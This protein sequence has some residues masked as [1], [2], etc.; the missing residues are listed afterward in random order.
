MPRTGPGK[1]AANQHNNRHENGLV[2][3]GKRIVKQKSNG[4]LNGSPKGGSQSSTPPL[5]TPSTDQPLTL[6]EDHNLNGSLKET[7]HDLDAVVDGLRSREAASTYENAEFCQNGTVSQPSSEAQ[8]PR[9]ADLNGSTREMTYTINPVRLVSSIVKACPIQDTIALLIFLLQLPPALLTTTQY[10]FATLSFVPPSVGPITHLVDLSKGSP[11]SPSLATVLVVSVITILCMMPLWTP[12]QNFALDIAQVQI[13]ITLG[14]GYS[15][16]S[17]YFDSAFVCILVVSA[18]HLSQS[19]DVRQFLAANVLSSW[20]FDVVRPR[21]PHV[22]QTI[23]PFSL[24]TTQHFQHI[25]PGWVRLIPAGHI[26]SQAAMR[27]V[28]RWLFNKNMTQLSKSGKAGDTEASAG[29]ASQDPASE[30]GSVANAAHLTDGQVASPNKIQEKTERISNTK[31]RKR[32]QTL[33]RSQ[34]PFWAALASTKVTVMRE[35]EHSRSGAPGI[36]TPKPLDTSSPDIMQVMGEE[37]RVW[38]LSV[39]PTTIK[40]DVSCATFEEQEHHSTALRPT[41]PF[42]LRVNGANWTSASI[43]PKH[44]TSTTDDDTAQHWIAEVFG[45]PPNGVYQCSMVRFDNEMEF[46][47]LNMKTPAAPDAEQCKSSA[48][49]ITRQTLI[50]RSFISSPATPRLATS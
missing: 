3:P 18:M 31:K 24:V 16:K 37:A 21:L 26:L 22:I 27:I 29:A 1:K 38:I 10:L 13:A 28:R 23:Q 47:V 41:P 33:V 6:G 25:P 8:Q 42:Y 32:Q 17:G 2:G 20:M 30:S 12:V 35:F 43:Y 49:P 4:H 48:S 34:Q 46:C 9:Q 5:P 45:L 50:S 11:G 40:F 36:A 14:G 39:Q 19:R 15:N 44:S 7:K